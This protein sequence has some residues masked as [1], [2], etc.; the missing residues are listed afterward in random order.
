MNESETGP[1]APAARSTSRHSLELKPDG[2]NI[3]RRLGTFLLLAMVALFAS[4]VFRCAWLCD[5]AY[6]TFR[7][8]QNF[9]QGY[10]P[11]WNVDERVQGYSHPLWMFVVSAVHLFTREIYY[12]SIFLSIGLAVATA[13]VVAAGA[14]S[15]FSG[16]L[17]L[18]LLTLSKAFVDFSTSGLENPATHLLL[19]L[20]Y[21]ILLRR[22]L[23]PRNFFWLALIACLAVLNRMDALLLF[24]PALVVAFIRLRSMRVFWI[25]A[26]AW[27]P[28]VAWEVFS[29]IYYGYPFPNTAYAK[30]GSGWDAS[31]LARQGMYYLWATFRMDQL[32]VGTIVLGVTAGLLSR[33]WRKI[34]AAIGILLYLAYVV[35]IGGDFMVGRFLS[36]SFLGAVVLAGDSALVARREARSGLLA[37]AVV[38]GVASAHPPIFSPSDYRASEPAVYCVDSRYVSDERGFYFR[39]TGLLPTLQG[40]TNVLTNDWARI[41]QRAREKKIPLAVVGS[42]GFCG[43]YAG[44][45]VHIV[46][47]LALTEPLLAR[48]PARNTRGLVIGHFARGIPTGYIPLLA[49]GD[50]KH[51]DPDL[52]EFSDKIRLIAR[53]PLFDAERM[54][55]IWNMNLGRYNHLIRPDAEFYV[56]PGDPPPALF[57]FPASRIREPLPEGTP[58]NDPRAVVLYPYS[59]GIRV[60]LDSP[61]HAER[62]EVSAAEGCGYGFAFLRDEI[63]LAPPANLSIPGVLYRGLKRAVIVAPPEAAKVGYDE[64][65]IT[66]QPPEETG[67]SIGHLKLL[68][69]AP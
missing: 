11:R 44:P 35:K 24:A 46:D 54:K 58:W 61:S 47:P 26:L 34:A 2:A 69:N 36:A 25:G 21:F 9:V 32:T 7:T 53:A 63:A 66:L 49:T 68:D 51:L 22:E 20:F 52:A 3:E 31:G 15:I 40:R 43:F 19:A 65:W 1:G 18:V 62:I 12:T 28:F 64:I 50:R 48:L 39:N 57:V 23:M 13:A 59:G 45:T 14:P 4:T 37:A 8:V 55:A 6:I 38:V 30:L 41:G 27:L 33:D 17:M 42:I 16:A 67:T 10:G 29:L 56:P 60:L 5:D